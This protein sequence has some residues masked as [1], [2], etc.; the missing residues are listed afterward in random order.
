MSD[1]K[2]IAFLCAHFRSS[3]HN[4]QSIGAGMF[5][6]AYRFDADEK[7]FVLRIGVTR[8]AFEKDR[9]ASEQLGQVIKI[10]HVLAIGEYDEVSFFCISEW[11]SGQ[12]LTDFDKAGTEALLP[13]L[14]ENLLAMSRVPVSSQTGFG[15]LNGV[16]QCRK[17]YVSWSDFLGAIDD[18]AETF[19]PRGDEIYRPWDELFTTTFLDKAIVQD[20]HQRLVSLL[21]FLPNEQH[22]VH[23]DFG[24]E[25]ALAEGNQ[26]TAIL[27][28]AELRC[29]DWLYD[30]AYMAYHD[31]LGVDYIGAFR[32]WAADK[33]LSVPNLHERVR[34]SYLHIFLGNIFLEANRNQRDWYD[35][36]IERYKARIQ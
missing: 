19:T 27:D 18:F 14:F 15:I 1:P 34:A 25:N 20:A 28:W 12:I 11:L 3:A 7:T 26:L 9:F 6:Q 16:G 22:Y 10:P 8:E 29:G 36:D 13:S 2:L 24:Y 35:E 31:T 32:Q 21:P 23:G 5:S 4:L 30:L 33:G 17:R